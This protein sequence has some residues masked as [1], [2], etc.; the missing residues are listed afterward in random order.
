MAKVLMFLPPVLF[1]GLAA[2]FIVGMNRE[3]PDSLP[4]ALAG[5]QAPAVQVTALA[6][7]PGFTDADLRKPGV[8]LVNFWASWC[9]PC[10]AEHPLLEQLASE[11]IT[12]YGVNYK[13]RPDDAKG[14]LAE[15]GN[16]FAAIGADQGRMAL[17]WG[18]YGVPETYV[19]NGDGQIVLRF[20]GPISAAEL[21][22]S[23]R[24]AIAEASQ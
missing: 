15:L 17:D 9:A 14:F 3:D 19:I 8:K 4:S 16:P 13:D 5:K 1:A 7:F 12:I 10:R 20:A 6:E 21:E 18:V 11:G 2:L 24:P 23:I 22:R